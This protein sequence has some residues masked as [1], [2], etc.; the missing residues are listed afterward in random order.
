MENSQ[1]YAREVFCYL[2]E[3]AE[4]S[5][6]AKLRLGVHLKNWPALRFWH[7]VGFDRLVDI[8]GDAEHSEGTNATAILEYNINP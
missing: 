5:G 8:V 2:A 7:K 4:K 6:F 1:G 3:E